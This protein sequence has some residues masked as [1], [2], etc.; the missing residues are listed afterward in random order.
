M[1]TVLQRNRRK[2]RNNSYPCVRPRVYCPRDVRGYDESKNAKSA[3]E[4][5]KRTDTELIWLF[6][7]ECKH[8]FERLPYKMFRTT[9]RWV[10]AHT[11][12]YTV[13]QVNGI[14]LLFDSKRIRL[15]VYLHFST[16]LYLI[17]S[18]YSTRLWTP[19]ILDTSY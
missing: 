11:K 6:C 10:I 1:F 19:T 13:P 5:S 12:F 3:R 14:Q 17:K 9:K 16:Q 15:P 8:D 2:R 4:V 7:P 18:P